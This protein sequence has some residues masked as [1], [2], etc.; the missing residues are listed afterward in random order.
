MAVFGRGIEVLWFALTPRV[1]HPLWQVFR[2]PMGRR[3][4]KTCVTAGSN[5]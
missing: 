3:P 4:R 2:A 1:H 5:A